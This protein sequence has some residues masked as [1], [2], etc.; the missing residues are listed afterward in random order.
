MHLFKNG[1]CK[2]CNAGLG[3]K[4]A[5]FAPKTA[6]E[7]RSKVVLNKADIISSVR[8]HLPQLARE[9]QRTAYYG[10]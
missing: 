8:V 3:A 10:A 2:R 9:E 4:S 6:A 1:R 7:R 5:C